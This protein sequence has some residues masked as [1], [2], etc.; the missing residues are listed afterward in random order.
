MDCANM[1]DQV[2]LATK[3]AI[4]FLAT[5]KRH[6]FTTTLGKLQEGLEIDLSQLSSYTIDS[7]S[8]T[9]SIGAGIGYDDFQDDLGAAGYM[10]RA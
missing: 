6:G 9:V 5:S 10:I 2:K 4:P 8:G 7:E 1:A 3:H